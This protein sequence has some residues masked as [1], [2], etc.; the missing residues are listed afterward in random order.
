MIVV[1]D[2]ISDIISDF[3]RMLALLRRRGRPIGGKRRWR[4]E[5]VTQ[6]DRCATGM[7]W[8]DSIHLMTLCFD[9]NAIIQVTAK[10]NNETDRI[11]R[12][13]YERMIDDGLI[14]QIAIILWSNGLAIDASDIVQHVGNQL[15]WIVVRVFGDAS[16]WFEKARFIH[17]DASKPIR[18][19]VTIPI[20]YTELCEQ[21][22]IGVI[23][24]LQGEKQRFCTEVC[25]V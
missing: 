4:G 3:Q 22:V 2:Q 19:F 15:F 11:P 18:H 1:L 17:R 7:C 21:R 8:I 16:D 25:C 12:R 20:A 24:Y 6:S 9:F 5:N 10:P 23:Q 13:R 14:S